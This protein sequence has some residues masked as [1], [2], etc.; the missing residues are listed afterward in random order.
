MGR[1]ELVLGP[2]CATG[3]RFA[4]GSR[5]LFGIANFSK[6]GRT[7]SDLADARRGHPGAISATWTPASFMVAARRS[8]KRYPIPSPDIEQE[9]GARIKGARGW[10]VNLDGVRPSRCTSR[11]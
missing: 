6:A 11:C 7:S 8:D 3:R 1:I 10:D 2:E 5:T 4:S 9:L